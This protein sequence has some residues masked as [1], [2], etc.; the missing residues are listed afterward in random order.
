MGGLPTVHGGTRSK[1]V[2]ITFDLALAS[3]LLLL[4]FAP[5]H[6]AG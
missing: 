5:A 3:S 1:Q 4:I 6:A 2:L